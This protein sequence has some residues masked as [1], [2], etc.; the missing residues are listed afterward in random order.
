MIYQAHPMAF[1]GMVLEYRQSEI[2]S[3]LL[4]VLGTAVLFPL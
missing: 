3:Y 2:E 4:R 1:A